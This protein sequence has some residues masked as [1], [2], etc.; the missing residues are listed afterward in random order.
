MDWSTS[1]RVS[2]TT[3]QSADVDREAVRD[4]ARAGFVMP[5]W[6]AM[7]EKHLAR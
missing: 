3:D 6:Q 1:A 7:L 2:G 5:T 4:V